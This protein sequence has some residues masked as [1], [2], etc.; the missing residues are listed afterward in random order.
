LYLA[1]DEARYTTGQLLFVDGGGLPP[2]TVADY[3]RG[4]RTGRG[5]AG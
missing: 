4:D 5:L 1:S 2:L 3:I